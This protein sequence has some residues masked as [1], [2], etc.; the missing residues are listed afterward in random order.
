M[1]NVVLSLFHWKLKITN[2]SEICLKSVS[3]KIFLYS[4]QEPGI[5][6]NKINL[7]Q[8]IPKYFQTNAIKHT[9]IFFKIIS[10]IEMKQI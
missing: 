6:P 1:L 10:D 8:F 7:W 4:F 3:L 9:L 2:Y 5:S